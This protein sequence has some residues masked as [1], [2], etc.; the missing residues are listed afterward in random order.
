MSTAMKRLD[1]LAAP[2]EGSNLIEANA[3]TGKTWTIT[4]LYL[5]LLLETG[6]DV[7][8]ILVVTFTEAATAELRERIRD[9]L[10]DARTALEASLAG[11]GDTL[12]DAL[13]SR[14]GREDALLRLTSAL[15]DFDQAPIYTIHGYCQR[16]LGDRAFES[17]MPFVTE[18]VPDQS[19]LLQEIVEDFWREHVHGASPLFMRFLLEMKVNP[20]ALKEAIERWIGKPYLEV[21]APQPR[22]D[23]A[24]LEHAYEAACEEARTIW[25]A[26]HEAVAAQ[27]VGNPGLHG[28]RYK[29]ASV[30]R[31]LRELDVFFEPQ[32]VGLALCEGVRKLTTE[33]LRSGTRKS[34]AAPTHPFYEACQALENAHRALLAAYEREALA[35]QARLLDYC[36]AELVKRK[37]AKDLQSYDDLLINLERALSAGT[38]AELA[39]AL[40][41]RYTAALIDEFQDTD[42]VQYAIF[43]RIYEGSDLPV[44]LVGDPKQSIYSFRGA[45]VYAYLKAQK[46]ARHA[47]TLDVNWRSEAGLLSAVNRLFERAP[48]PFVIEEIAFHRSQP[49]AGSRGRL[50]LEGEEGAPLHVW[51][52]ESTDGKPLTKAAATEAAA[53]ATAAEIA[54]LLNL[55]T[56]SRARIA[57]PVGEG[58]HERALCGGDIAVLTRTHRQAGAVRQALAALGVASVLRDGESVF[59]SDEA[60]ELECV[61]LAIAEPGR[62]ALIGAALTTEMLGLSG[63]LLYTLRADE[64]RWEEV[65]GRFREAHREW[66]ERG[67]MPMLRSFLHHHDVVCRLLAYA[68]GERRVTNLM[69]LAELIHCES[70]R[71]GIGGLLAWL[72]GKRA[73]RA[74]AN[75]AELLRLE[76]D[77]NLV[78]ILTV[79]AAKGLEYPLVFC[80][81]VWDSSLRAA[82]S[83]AI[84]FHDP[85]DE[86]RA[87]LDVG[88]D[89]Q[90]AWRTQAM[91]EELAESL[92]LFYVALTRA[93]YR[94][95]L[96]WGNVKDA[97]TAAPAWL[98]HRPPGLD[99]MDPAKLPPLGNERVRADLERMAAASEGAICVSPILTRTGVRYE[100]VEAAAPLLA[101]RAFTGSLRDTRWV[102]SFS[103]LAHGR[104]VEAPDYDAGDAETQAEAAP[105]ARGIFAFPRGAHAGKCLHTIFEQVDFSDL[106][107]PELERLIAKEL[108]AHAFEGGWV[109]AVADMVEAVAATPLDASGMRLDRIRR[110]KRLDELE[111]YYPIAGLSDAVFRQVLLQWGFPDDIR[112]SIGK[113]TF[114]PAQGY[115]RGFIDLVFEHEGRYYL[116]D[117]KSNWLGASVQAYRQPQL[118]KA[119]ARDAYYLQYLVYC[120]ALHRYLGSRVRGYRYAAHFGG[121]RYLFVRGMRP[122]SGHNCGVYAD[123]P[124][125]DLIHALDAYL[126]NGA[127]FA[128]HTKPQAERS[129]AATSWQA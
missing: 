120:V 91:R 42:P 65:T 104:M 75:D 50:L 63:E 39:R 97:H 11:A 53:R 76:S 21:R 126:A 84:S 10:A 5:R 57:V 18:I 13:L 26:H 89:T 25:L 117:Y 6:R 103:A 81:F 7:A 60:R 129:D 58:V 99:T 70:A 40:R 46:E 123:C 19:M 44:F 127:P 8:S 14:V 94:C 79:H 29:A 22:Q 80:P 115:M 86:D 3:G 12:L 82:K 122:H 33:A 2:L 31:W 71:Y 9:R 77:E 30:E 28:G 128:E 66:R 124:P 110:S 54:R 93:K 95:W 23:L 90:D 59:H 27:L 43:S 109:R 38:G 98:L 88:S 15:R 100:P 64:E 108:A 106:V 56:R 55:G 34:A 87:V 85:T 101:A 48:L 67:F 36:N 61:L 62:E 105:G 32:S 41:T 83:P 17:G 35:L 69:H 116:A 74:S 107:R 16:V 24:Q 47:H 92:R 52:L 119:M 45:D 112:E 72:S 96:V 125:E 121:V 102:T 1:V 37:E 73:A 78:K 4:T 114:A 113:L 20:P 51:L 49:A 118:A 68:D 111:F